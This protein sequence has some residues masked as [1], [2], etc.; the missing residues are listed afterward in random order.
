MQPTSEFISS[1][2]KRQP[3][4]NLF[5]WGRSTK[6]KVETFCSRF[7]STANFGG[8]GGEANIYLHRWLIPGLT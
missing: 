7:T 4:V 5:F 8:L 6:L 2:S 3:A 1:S